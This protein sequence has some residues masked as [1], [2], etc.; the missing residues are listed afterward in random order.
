MT[1]FIVY[2]FY[3]MRTL[4]FFSFFFKRRKSTTY[5]VSKGPDFSLEVKKEATDITFEMIQS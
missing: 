1:H 3:R 4:K 5:S 2:F